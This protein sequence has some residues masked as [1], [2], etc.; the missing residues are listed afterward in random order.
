MGHSA[1]SSNNIW[2]DQCRWEQWR[3]G[4]LWFQGN[5]NNTQG[6]QMCFVTQAKFE[7]HVSAGSY[8]MRGPAVKLDRTR[9]IFMSQMHFVLGGRDTVDTQSA[10]YGIHVLRSRAP[11]IRDVLMAMGSD[12]GTESIDAFIHMDGST[13][14]G[15]SYPVLRD[16][17]LTTDS[18]GVHP[19]TAL[20][21]WSG[22]NSNVRISGVAAP[23]NAASTTLTSGSATS[24]Y[25]EPTWT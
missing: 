14:S 5:A 15:N 6:A 22:T 16:I 7:N 24:V 9:S 23:T 10:T 8:G 20:I 12:G 2:F 21:K 25:S 13:G 19:S 1:D 11:R 17:D 4:A 3:D 18:A